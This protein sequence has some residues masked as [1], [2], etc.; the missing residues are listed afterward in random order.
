MIDQINSSI[1][2][3]CNTDYCEPP[4]LKSGRDWLNDNTTRTLRSLEYHKKEQLEEKQR[5]AERNN[6]LSALRKSL[7]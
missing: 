3:D 2:F 6:W 4:R 7:E 1:K 5:T